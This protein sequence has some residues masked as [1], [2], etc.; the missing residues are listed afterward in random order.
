[1][2]IRRLHRVAQWCLCAFVFASSVALE[3]QQR[4]LKTDTIE[5][6]DAVLLLDASG[7]MRVT[8][9]KQLR[10]EGAKLFI[11]FLKPG[12]RLSIIAFD[13]EARI[14]RPL[15][16]YERDQSDAITKNVAEVG[17]SGE[18]TDLL[19]GIKAAKE[20][21]EKEIRADANPVIVLLSDGKMDPQPIMGS[22]MLRT[23]DLMNN[24]MPEL[25]AKGIK[26]HTLAFSEQADKELL[27]QV[28]LATEGQH[29]FTPSSEKV[30]ESYAD[31]FLVVKKPQMLPLTAKGFRIDAN[32]EE[33]T[34]YVNR[35]EGGDLQV[36]S[37]GGKL[38]NSV[39]HPEDIKWFRG[40]KFDVVTIIKP[41]V[42]DWQ[43][44]GL[45][46]SEGFA[47][48]LTNLKLITDWPASINVG[49]PVLLQARLYEAD[50]PIVL[51]E[52]SG[53]TRFAAQIIPT[54]KVSE[55]I[56]RE[57]LFDDGTHGD[58]IARDGIFSYEVTFDEPGDHRLQIVSN[59]PT[60]ER[61]QQILFRVKPRLI[62][63]SVSDSE[64]SGHGSHGSSGHESGDGHAAADNKTAQADAAPDGH[65]HPDAHVEGEAKESKAEH[66]E[67][68]LR[69]R[70]FL[71]QLSSEASS[72]KGIEIKIVA[73]DKNRKRFVLPTLPAGELTFRAPAAGLPHDGLYE[74]QATLSAERK[75]TRIKE[76][77][78]SITF[79]KVA[80]ADGEEEVVLA[81]VEK[82]PEKESPVL[83]IVIVTLINIAAGVVCIVLLKKAQG[84]AS[85][86]VP[87]FKPLGE[88]E[89]AIAKLEAVALLADVDLNDPNLTEEKVAALPLRGLAS[90]GAAA[91]APAAQAEAAPVEAPAPE[92]KGD[93]AA[94]TADS[95]EGG[96][97]EAA[98]AGE[99]TK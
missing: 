76:E 36:R 91:P 19:A 27:Q 6:V 79:E 41:E 3:A 92:A 43:V 24:Y 35:D 50:K 4:E 31:L 93:E 51:P 82:T 87:E 55:P 62:E 2:F 48:V 34:F 18:Y 26:V 47:T 85:F 16:A 69:G 40:Q 7:S 13:S 99:E 33:A 59:A 67:K 11:Q 77:S 45:P 58:K 9:P 89:E 97:A 52:M 64:A 74:V 81:V 23:T 53:A 10:E 66:K 84:Q 17:N 83:P 12:D 56:L 49:T 5:K 94:T 30:H 32:I 71:V 88:V 22:P 37:P 38:F 65:E 42:G 98:P 8:D 44:E 20:L 95:A 29:W 73:V 25:K 15:S 78:N 28:A 90:G 54:D 14:I 75:R 61:R 96:N 1:M 72:L 39:D 63:L 86:S 46:S 70:Y 57:S 80:P 68:V 60:F 21:L